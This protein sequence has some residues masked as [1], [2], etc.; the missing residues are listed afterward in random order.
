MSCGKAI[1]TVLKSNRHEVGLPYAGKKHREKSIATKQLDRRSGF[2]LRVRH[3]FRGR[4]MVECPPGV[5]PP[6]LPTFLNGE[7]LDSWF[8]LVLRGE[9]AVVAEPTP[10]RRPAQI[11]D[12]IE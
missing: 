5:E 11:R 7:W 1:T 10:A 6:R 8:E 2:S 9:G 4:I 12:S 3:F